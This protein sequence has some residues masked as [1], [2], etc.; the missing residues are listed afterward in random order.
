MEFRKEKSEKSKELIKEH[1]K[2][3]IFNIDTGYYKTEKIYPISPKPN[4]IGKRLIEFTPKYPEVKHFQRKFDS[5]LSD[6]QKRT[7]N[8]L[9][10]RPNHNIK[11]IDLERSR[12][13]NKEINGYCVD[14]KGIFS[15]KKL[16]ILDFYGTRDIIN[17]SIKNLNLT[18][19]DNNLN[20]KSIKEK[21]NLLK[22]N[23]SS[24]NLYLNKKIKLDNGNLSNLSLTNT[25]FYYRKYNENNIKTESKAINNNLKIIDNYKSFNNKKIENYKN[26]NSKINDNYKSTNK[27]NDNIN[28]DLQKINSL[29]IKL[30]SS[31]KKDTLNFIKNLIDNKNKNPENNHK[32]NLNQNN[33]SISP[34]MKK[35]NIPKTK[36]TKTNN[37]NKE[38]QDYEIFN[39]EIKNNDKD[40]N[41]DGKKIKK[42]LYKNGLHAYD[43]DENKAN[44]FLYEN[45]VISLKI[46]KRK[47]D[48]NFDKRLKKAEKEFNK[49]NIKINRFSK[50]NWRVKRKGTPGN[51]LRQKNENE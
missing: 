10:L 45:N 35:K 13:R 43:F 36:Y 44:H 48:E 39:V 5:F 29:I 32:I 18:K 34:I 47:G 41:I 8:I 25:A 51:E 9:N 24:K 46:R 37:N 22:Q 1:S 16:Y 50:I 33:I 42:I 4:E 15:A 2:S 23:K 26:C 17:N 20:N 7:T 27:I 28:D 38:Y 14:K 21:R 12:T 11:N 40:E 30:N 3:N 49:N 31:Q 6:Q 19:N